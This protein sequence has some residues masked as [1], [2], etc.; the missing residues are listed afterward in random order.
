LDTLRKGEPL[1]TTDAAPDTAAPAEVSPSEVEP[2]A[3]ET[4]TLQKRIN[5]TIRSYGK[6][7]RGSGGVS[8]IDT[9]KENTSKAQAL[10]LEPDALARA[11]S[12]FDQQNFIPTDDPADNVSSLE[13]LL[14]QEINDLVLK[15]QYN[16]IPLEGSDELELLGLNDHA[17]RARHLLRLIEQIQGVN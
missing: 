3:F 12:W 15:A 13:F 1:P 2:S 4:E 8:G 9:V 5:D 10:S 11:A 6:L 17:A 16:D 14:Q 7:S